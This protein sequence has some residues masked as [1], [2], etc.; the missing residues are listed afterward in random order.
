M[1]QRMSRSSLNR[2]AFLQAHSLPCVRAFS[3]ITALMRH[4]LPIL[5]MTCTSQ[6]LLLM[7]LCGSCKVPA[8]SIWPMQPTEHSQSCA[9][10]DS[11]P[12]VLTALLG[13]T[14]YYS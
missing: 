9:K 4:F 10:Q 13:P 14:L 8:N 11:H 6:L 5:D 12:Q 7:L 1:G 2:R 3:L